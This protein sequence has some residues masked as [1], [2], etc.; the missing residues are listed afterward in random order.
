MAD[1]RDEQVYAGVPVSEL[2]EPMPLGYGPEVRTLTPEE[3]ADLR[4]YLG[5][6]TLDHMGTYVPNLLA[7]L[8]AARENIAALDRECAQLIAERARPDALREAAADRDRW[9][10][11]AFYQ[12]RLRN[13]IAAADRPVTDLGD[14]DPFARHEAQA[15]LRKSVAAF[16]RVYDGPHEGAWGDAVNE[17]V[18]EMRGALDAERSNEIAVGNATVLTVGQRVVVDGTVFEVR[19]GPTLAPV[20]EVFDMVDDEEDDGD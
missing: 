11:E 12:Y 1:Q 4:A 17:A 14:V 5:S 2:Q 3:L 10:D 8:D 6:M 18:A 20:G 7:T 9:R 16:F 15:R 19:P 13:G